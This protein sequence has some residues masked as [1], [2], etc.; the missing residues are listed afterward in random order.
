MPRAKPVLARLSELAEGQF[1]DF[2]ALLVERARGATRDGKPY[3]TCRFRDAGRT[4]TFM[5]WAD[6]PWFEACA[7]EWHE[8]RFFKIRG[9]YGTHERYG[10]Q[11]DIHNIRAVQESDYTE[12]FDPAALAAST[13][14][15][16]VELFAE[17]LQLAEATI[18]DA[19]LRRLVLT[20]LE[21]H[22]VPLKQLPA[23]PRHF[24]PYPGGLLEHL[25][26][27]TKTCLRLVE[28]YASHFADLKP[29]L[30]RDIVIAGAI[31]HDVG[32][33]V[34]FDDPLAL[35]ATI[36]GRLF[37]HLFLGR[38]LIHDTAREL[39]DVNP[40]L[41]QLLEHVVIA[42]LNHP[43]W[44]SPRL[45]LIPE[46]LILHHAD[47][48][49]AKLE[50]YVRCLTTDQAAGPFTDRDSALGRHLFKGRSV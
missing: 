47:D 4:A 46:C 18:A 39:G 26:S 36:A 7:K 28:H 37:G 38:D 45:P 5:V 9:T 12:G 34:E 20:L 19:P 30:N 24:Y 33:V 3:Y 8:G 16:S 22:A 40:E 23:T 15:D 21:R 43:E 6:A 10:P 42:H 44:G 41:L 35:Q 49:D 13:R 14:R 17:L 50:M 1:A 31:L 29:P 48:L 27:V 25:L 32:R 11:L 2:F